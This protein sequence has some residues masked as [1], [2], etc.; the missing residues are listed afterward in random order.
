VVKKRKN[1]RGTEGTEITEATDYAPSS[2]IPISSSVSPYELVPQSINLPVRSIDLP[3]EQLLGHRNLGI[4]EV[5]A[6][7]RAMAS[8]CP[9]GRP[10]IGHGCTRIFTELSL[11]FFP[12]PSV[13]IRVPFNLR[14]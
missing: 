9:I 10:G 5:H 12:C 14:M 4:G 6:Q 11:Y 13:E 7:C 3:L 2:T 1:H 8:P